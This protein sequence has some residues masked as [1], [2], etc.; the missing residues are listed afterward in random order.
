MAVYKRGK[1]YWYKFVFNGR[2]IRA[3]AKT[4]NRRVAEQIEAAKKT[5]LAKREVGLDVVK[6]I[7]PTLKEP[8]SEFLEWSKTEHAT[9]LAT[10]RRYE[11]S[12]KPLLLYYGDKTLDEITSDDVEKYKTWRSKQ[13]KKP[14]IRK[15]KKNK[16]AT[17]NKLLKPATVNRELACLKIVFNHFI[18]SDVIVK[19]PVSKVKFLKEDN[20]NF[21]VLT[22]EEERLYLMSAS[23]PLQDV[24]ILMLECG[25]R[26]DEIYNLTKRDINLEQEFLMI[27]TGKTNAARRKIPLSQK[28]K[29]VLQSRNNNAT[30]EFLFSGGRGGKEKTKPIVKLNNAHNG[31][32]TRANLRDFRLY[33]LRH[34]FASRMAM[35]GVDLVTLAALLGHSRVQM[36]MRYAHPVEEHKIDAIKKL[37][38]F[39]QRKQKAA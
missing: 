14:P 13:R 39:N 10:T 17:T 3:S 18:K 1:T 11:T 31:A 9:K 5:Q 25:C 16:R 32:R 23:Q 30:S 20:E 15:L 8:M 27:Q 21:A 2:T 29:A 4:T 33:D 12:S 26:P 35:A 28:A 34:T 36:V 19:N 24:A 6:M 38:N 22:A 37:E 7:V